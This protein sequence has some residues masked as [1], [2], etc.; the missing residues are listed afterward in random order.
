M[1]GKNYS[2][3]VFHPYGLTNSSLITIFGVILTSKINYYEKVFNN[4]IEYASAC[5]YSTRA[6][7]FSTQSKG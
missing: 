6:Y 1:S 4:C 5:E 7:K 3:H 2:G